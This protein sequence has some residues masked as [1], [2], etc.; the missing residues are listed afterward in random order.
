MLIAH[1]Y[2]ISCISLKHKIYFTHTLNIKSNL[3]FICFPPALTYDLYLM[4]PTFPMLAPSFTLAPSF[5]STRAPSPAPAP[6]GVPA[7]SHS[8]LTDGN[9]KRSKINQL[10]KLFLQ[11]LLKVFPHWH[12]F[13]LRKQ[14][15]SHTPAFLKTQCTSLHFSGAH[16]KSSPCSP[17][18]TKTPTNAPCTHFSLKYSSLDNNGFQLL[19]Q[20][21]TVG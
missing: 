13:H 6:Y 7:L 20:E 18:F 3:P 9:A 17:I 19:L 10:L 15:L 5:I 14:P 16:Q 8:F 1:F 11:K 4:P 12:Q 2:G 21:E